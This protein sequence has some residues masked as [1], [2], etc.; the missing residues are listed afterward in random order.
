[1]KIPLVD[2]VEKRFYDEVED[3]DF[4]RVDADQGV[5]TLIKRED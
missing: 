3:G 2:G 1:M 5:I 4:V